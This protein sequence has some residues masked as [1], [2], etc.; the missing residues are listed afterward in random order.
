MGGTDSPQ[1][2]PHTHKLRIT[3]ARP[4]RADDGKRE[5]LTLTSTVRALPTSATLRLNEL[6]TARS[7]A[8]Q[9][10][11]HLGFGEARFPLLPVLRDGLA[12]GAA[13]TAYPPVLGQPELREAR[14]HGVDGVER[15]GAG[16][17]FDGEGSARFAVVES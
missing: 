5:P 15:V 9:E 6:V 17:E 3:A 12:E 4:R 11:I 10:T 7:A 16:S 8:G 2:R 13:S 14:P 1:R